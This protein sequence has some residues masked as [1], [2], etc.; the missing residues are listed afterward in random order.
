MN[1]NEEQYKNRQS[2]SLNNQNNRGNQSFQD[3]Q[4]FQDGQEFQGNQGFEGRQS[5]Q[6]YQD[7]HINQN[8]RDDWDFHGSRNDRISYN[9][10]EFIKFRPGNSRKLS[11]VLRG[12]PWYVIALSVLGLV[13]I[14]FAFFMEARLDRERNDSAGLGPVSESAIQAELDELGWVEQVFLPV[15]PFSRPGIKL[16]GINGIVIHNIGNPSTTAMQNR[17]FFANLAITQERH[18][19]S[20]F[21]VC[22]DGIIIQCVPVDEMAYASNERNSDTLSIE[23]CHPDDTGKFTDESYAAA[24]RLTAWLS[25][26]FGLSAEDIIRHYDVERES[27]PKACPLYF[28]ENEDAW[29][30]FKA[31]VQRV[32]DGS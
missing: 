10:D 12:I 16:D 4:G 22:L 20:N 7:F 9:N 2:S 23:I 29:E 28:V 32:I 30:Q 8:P 24:V 17:N 1:N 13:V 19:S 18:A 31:D 15:N 21:I 25:V 27:G 11:P 5:P 3:R 6:G 14:L 26:R